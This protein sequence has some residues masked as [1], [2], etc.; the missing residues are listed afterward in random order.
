MNIKEY[1]LTSTE[2]PSDEFLHELMLQVAESA[3]TSSARAEQALRKMMME[4]ILF[5]K[6]EQNIFK[7]IFELLS[8]LVGIL[9]FSFGK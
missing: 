6:K 5:L 7:K 3:R 1:R 2:E 4:T 8:S 9:L